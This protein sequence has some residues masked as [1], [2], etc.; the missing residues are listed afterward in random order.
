[1]STS[2]S[3]ESRYR[4][5]IRAYPASWR[6]KHGEELVGVLLDVAARQ[7]RTRA[8]AAELVHLMVHGAAARVN[9]VLSVV[10]RRRRDRI[11]AIGTVTGTALA[12]V[13]LVLGELGRWFRWNSYTIADDPFG[14]FTTPAAI[15]FLLTIAAFLALAAGRTTLMKILHGTVIVAACFLAVALRTVDQTIPVN[16]LVF[17]TFC[18]T[19]LLSLIGDSTRTPALQH[20]VLLGAPALGVIITATSYLQGG[21]AQKTFHGQ[22]EGA[23]NEY[24]LTRSALELLL[25]ATLIALAGRKTLPW[26]CLVLIT[27]ASV[28]VT[29]LFF[30]LGG[31]PSIGLIGIQPSTFQITCIIIAVACAG[32]AWK[33]PVISFKDKAPGPKAAG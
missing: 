31:N 12:L 13:M 5:A 25:A 10:P 28:P 2:P 29:R 21:G 11:A 16:D 20:M 1:V 23:I 27:L 22:W 19:S 17:A 14:S 3:L 7:N 32:L 4:R 8:T 6:A 15:L 30:M 24:M 9:Q 33:R 26:A 18:L